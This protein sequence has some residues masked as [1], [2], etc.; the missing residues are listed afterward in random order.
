MI[1][2]FFSNNWPYRGLASFSLSSWKNILFMFIINI[3]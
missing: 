3:W 2:V 1:S